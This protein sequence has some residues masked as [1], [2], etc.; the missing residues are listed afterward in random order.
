M[1]EMVRHTTTTPTAQDFASIEGT[2]IVLDT[3]L[4]LAYVLTDGGLVVSVGL[5]SGAYAPGSM[6]IPTGRFLMWGKQLQL[7]GTQRLT[8]Q[9]TARLSLY[10]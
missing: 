2:P 7:T 9:G 4:G 10:N 6:T 8:L 1:R 5:T 3:V